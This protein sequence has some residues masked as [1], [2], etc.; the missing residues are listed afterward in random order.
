M[1][2]KLETYV[3][4]CN[5]DDC[6]KVFGDVVEMSQRSVIRLAEHHGWQSEP[7]SDDH[8]AAIYWYCPKCA[9]RRK[10]K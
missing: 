10:L 3:I 6:D 7:F 8:N 9:E 5:G 2:R 4:D 1:I